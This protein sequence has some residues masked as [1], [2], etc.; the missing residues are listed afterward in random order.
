MRRLII[1]TSL[2]TIPIT[3]E[4]YPQILPKTLKSYPTAPFTADRSP[5]VRVFPSPA[6][7]SVR[8]RIGRSVDARCTTILAIEL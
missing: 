8:P 4:I 7:G 6:A 3:V 2:P 1:D 5:F